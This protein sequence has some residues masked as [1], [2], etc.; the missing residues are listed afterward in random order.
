MF[1]RLGLLA[2][3]LLAPAV[4]LGDSLTIAESNNLD[5]TI[6]LAECNNT[7]QDNLSFTWAVTG[8]TLGGTFDLVVSN[9]SSCPDPSQNNSAKT[10]PIRL[11]L[12]STVSSF[13]A[14]GDTPVNVSGLIRSLGYSCD[15]SAPT[16]LVFCVRL[17]AAGTVSTPVS[18]G[19]TLDFAI[20]VAP[21]ITSVAPAES[22]LVVNWTAGLGGAD[23]G[24]SGSAVSFNLYCAPPGTDVNTVTS[25]CG[26]VSGAGSTQARASGLTNGVTYDVQ[27]T[28]V[29]QGG[30]EST[31]SNT[32]QGTPQPVNDFW[33]TYRNAGGREGGGCATGAA[34]LAALAALLP[35]AFRRRRR[36]P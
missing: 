16:T 14:A 28:S 31:R 19:L 15:A 20:P 9:T 23:A 25:T 10:Q 24:T 6:N 13:P 29:S 3:V 26:T 12:A 17:N 2:A 1:P 18:T 32:A 33:R 4:A 21:E 30:N 35:L 11:G 7:K 36:R 8:A 27:V 22:G 34:G 5:N